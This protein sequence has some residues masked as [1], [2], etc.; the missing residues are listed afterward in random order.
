MQVPIP[1]SSI[2]DHKWPAFAR[3]D[4]GSIARVE[5]TDKEDGAKVA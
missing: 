2:L 3:Q 5:E 1:A 4:Q